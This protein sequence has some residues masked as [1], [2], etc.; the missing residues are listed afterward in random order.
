M[1]LPQ[2]RP[3]HSLALGERLL[4]VYARLLAAYGP[5][6]W[7]PGSGDPFEIVVGA[8][9][10]QSVAWVNVEKALENLR[11]A[12]ALSPAG[13]HA[14]P[15]ESLAALLRPSGYYTVKARR[16]RA[17]VQVVMEEFG[18]DLR[19]L[20]A[21]PL[22]AL[23]ARLLGTYGIGQETADDIIVYAAGQPSF[24][25][26]AYTVRLFTRLGLGPEPVAIAPRQSRPAA[27]TAKRAAGA[28]SAEVVVT[29]R[30]A[31]PVASAGADG[32]VAAIPPPQ[33]PPLVLPLLDPRRYAAW[34]A[35]FMAH[36]PPDIS[37]FNEYHALIVRHGVMRCRKRIPHCAGCP[38]LVLCPTGQGLV[39][40]I[41][42]FPLH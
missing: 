27:G 32:A 38:L 21:L 34:Q 42:Q 2:G 16:L 20:L 37:L 6:G 23:R 7:W 36:L 14:L 30:T 18:G 4:D 11:A 25:V 35:F 12:G 19:R 15:D 13:V 39:S 5:Q 8:V 41:L 17:V 22:P 10:T 24:V 33:G 29:A 9:L 40:L 31:A 3:A 28:A 1:S 26:D